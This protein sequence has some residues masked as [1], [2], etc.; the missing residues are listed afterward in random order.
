[1]NKGER[2]MNKLKRKQVMIGILSGFG[3]LLVFGFPMTGFGEIGNILRGEALFDKN[4][5]L[6]HGTSAKGNG[7]LAR[8]LPVQPADLTDCRLT[9]EDPVEV[10]EGIIREGG[11]YTGLSKVMPAWVYKLSSQEISDIAAFVKT[12]CA[13]K[14]WITG[15]LNFPRPLITGKAFPEQEMIGGG[16]F[17]QG[18]TNQSSAKISFEYRIGGLTNIGVSTSAVRVDPRN[19][20]AHSGIGDSSVSIKRVIAYDYAQS[21]LLATSLKLQ[22]PTGDEDRS[23]GSGEYIWQPSLRA[24]WRKG[25]LVTQVDTRVTIPAETSNENTKIR[26]NLAL[27]YMIEPDPR[28]EVTPMIEIVNQSRVNGPNSGETL[29]TAVPQ[30]RIKW[31]QWSTGFGVEVPVSHKK[32][33]DFRALFDLTYEYLLF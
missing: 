2:K 33:F 31:L 15:D 26:Y 21:F 3:L 7:P 25:H 16:Q 19:A 29:S 27:G 32:D 18:D 6:C 30:I 8:T 4:C 28:L 12:L 14:Q 13:D 9:A 1:M 17:A 24:G 22:F 10:L 5:I 23:L 20:S 11:T